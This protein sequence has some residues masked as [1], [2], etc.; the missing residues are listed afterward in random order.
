METK[1]EWKNGPKAFYF[2]NDTIIFLVILRPRKHLLDVYRLDEGK[3]GKK[4]VTSY[5]DN[6][7]EWTVKNWIMEENPEL[8]DDEWGDSE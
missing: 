7:S 6:V 1:Q 5:P 4:Y 2:N 3:K 8:V